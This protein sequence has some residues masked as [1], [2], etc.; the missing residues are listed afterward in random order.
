MKKVIEIFW[1]VVEDIKE[2]FLVWGVK[3][4]IVLLLLMVAHNVLKLFSFSSEA[5]EKY[6]NLITTD[7]EN[8]YA[9]NVY[10]IGKGDKTIVILPG[11]GSQSPILQYKELAQGLSD[12]Y[13]VVIIEYYGYGFST[14]NTT[15][16]R[17]SAN[18]ADEIV[19]VLKLAKIDGP[20]YLMP[21]SIS[22]MYAIRLQQ[23]RPDL[24]TGIISLDGLYPAEIND[25]YYEDIN[26]NTITN[27]KI[28][29]ALEL[30]GFERLLSYVSPSTFYINKMK[31][32]SA[33][34]AD[35]IKI[36]RDRIAKSYLTKTMVN[37]IKMLV[38][39]M[40]ELKDYKYPSNL[41]VLQ[42]LSEDRVKQYKNAK[43]SKGATVDL[44]ELANGMITNSSIQTVVTIEGDHSLELTNPSGVIQEVVQYLLEN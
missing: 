23:K 9:I 44:E 26:L 4:L 7:K 35:D 18:I 38:K 34:T 37:E 27:V 28:T 22:N 16:E 40:D 36:Y 2:F 19:K 33:Y 3:I 42:I 20:Y 15:S 5:E 25:K 32:S 13:K 41:P 11:F 29:A 14:E 43:E 10:Q 1:I 39:N 17:T 12:K 6:K 31:E 30:T 8:E 24:V 21:H